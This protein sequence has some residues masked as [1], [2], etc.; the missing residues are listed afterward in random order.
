MGKASNKKKGRTANNEKK[1]KLV[2]GLVAM[3]HADPNVKVERNVE[4]VGRTGTTKRE[5]DVLVTAGV[6]GYEVQLAFECKNEA[7]PIGVRY[8][9]AFRGKLDYLGIPRKYGKFVSASGYTKGALEAANDAGIFALT[10]QGLTKDRLASMV[11]DA[12]Q[13]IVYLLPEITTINVMNEID[14]TRAPDLQAELMVF[15]DQNGNV[16]GSVPDLLWNAWIRGEIPST[17]GEHDLK[18]SVPTH[19]RYIISGREEKLLEISGKVEVQGIL[20]TRR[21]KATRHT[22]LDANSNTMFKMNVASTFDDTQQVLP[23]TVVRNEDELN[24]FISRQGS[25]NITVGRFRLPRMRLGAVYYP[26]SERV[27]RI[28]INQMKAFEAGE[29][30]DPRP[31]SFT[32]L[33]GTDLSRVFEPIWGEH[34][35]MK[36]KDWI[37][38]TQE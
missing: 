13:H 19:W 35:A 31:F 25:I 36:K 4:L 30:P 37:N 8:I 27:V 32:E 34:P 29:I 17:F 26:P 3:F 15:R 16:C 12:F 2:E 9:D 11:L 21:G 5:I 10:L 14:E 33:E 1:G 28:T 22:L 38:W 24:T 6:V 18:L 7:K 23:V 20:V